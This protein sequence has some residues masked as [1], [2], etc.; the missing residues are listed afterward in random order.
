MVRRP[1]GGQQL[2]LTTV[3][4]EDWSGG[5]A[6]QREGSLQGVHQEHV[7]PGPSRPEHRRGEWVR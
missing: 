4:G 1:G 6:F 2:W 5:G 3:L 7:G